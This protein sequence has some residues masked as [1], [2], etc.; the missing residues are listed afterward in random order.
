MKEAIENKMLSELGMAPKKAV[1]VK[2]SQT[3]AFG[4]RFM[5][6]KPK[7]ILRQ[8]DTRRPLP[9]SKSYERKELERLDYKST[10]PNSRQEFFRD[11]VARVGWNWDEAISAVDTEYYKEIQCF[12]LSKKRELFQ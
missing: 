5:P 7:P 1:A 8:P 6:E 2:P 9:K 11:W 10:P 4:R 12:F 3:H